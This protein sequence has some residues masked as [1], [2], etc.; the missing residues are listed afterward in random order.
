MKGNGQENSGNIK[1]SEA[2]DWCVKYHVKT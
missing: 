2:L 1:G